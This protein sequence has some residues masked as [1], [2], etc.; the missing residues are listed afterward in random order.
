MSKVPR[1]S[2]DHQLNLTQAIIYNRN[3]WSKQSSPVTCWFLCF[4]V[5]T[6]IC[7]NLKV[8]F[9][10]WREFRNEIVKE[11]P[12]KQYVNGTKKERTSISKRENYS[13]KSRCSIGVGF[14]LFLLFCILFCLLFDFT[15]SFWSI[16]GWLMSFSGVLQYVMVEA[17]RN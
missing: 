2:C 11:N 13:N 9:L 8:F 16:Y 14:E 15:P 3:S 10:R 7:S 1:K 6:R 12:N 5:Q 4:K 17:Q